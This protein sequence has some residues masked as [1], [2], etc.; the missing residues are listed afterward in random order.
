MGEDSQSDV[1]GVRVTSSR[2]KELEEYAKENG[3]DSVP[4]LFRQAVA[5]EMADDYGLLTNQQSGRS[6]EE[7]GEVV[8]TVSRL[9][10]QINDLTEEVSALS[11]E[12]RSDRP[13]EVVE[14]MSAVHHVLPTNEAQAME[15]QQVAEQFDDMNPQTAWE[16]LMHLYEETGS[17]HRATEGGWFKDA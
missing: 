10:T 5:H 9:K 3:Y 15:Y 4:S 2:R 13:P 1:V 17:V 11:E 16:T 12:I 14:R 7:L 8:T 6:P